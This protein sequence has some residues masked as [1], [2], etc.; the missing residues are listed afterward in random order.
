MKERETNHIIETYFAFLNNKKFPCVG[1][2][3]AMAK[4]QV[5]CMVA[6]HMGCPKDDR[7]ILQF[8][9]EFVD[10]Y[11]LSD[12]IFYSAAIIFEEPGNLTEKIFD[13]LLWQRLQ[14][15]ANLDAEKCLYDKRVDPDPSSANFSFSIKEE[16]FFIIGLHPASSRASR[17]FKYPTLVFNPH[18]QFE[19]LKITNK[20]ELMKDAT[21]KR[22]IA[23]SGS[24]NPMLD[25]FG[26]SSE[27]FQYSGRRYNE[28]WQC[29]LHINH[30]KDEHNTTS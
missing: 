26:N 6:D 29:P 11:R 25:D 23:Y 15:L 16:A 19:K 7:Y 12:G 9:Y 2:K 14:A 24:V 4:Q 8:L 27:A 10:T 3:A 17:Q 5:K 28:Q 20:Y 21:R 18:E 1:A 22:D 30:T 13:E